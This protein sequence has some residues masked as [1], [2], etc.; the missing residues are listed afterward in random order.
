[1]SKPCSS[2]GKL[3]SLETGEP[4]VESLEIDDGVVT[5]TVHLMKTSACCGDDMKEYT[6]ELEESLMDPLEE[7]IL[8]SHKELTQM[9]EAMDYD[10]FSV[11]EGSC[12]VTE[13]GGSRYAKSYTGVELQITVKCEQDDCDWEFAYTLFGSV[14]NGSFEEV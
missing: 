8:E 5:A 2:C 12:E 6:Y 10:V 9:G 14:P 7:H 4:E 11:E 3:A 13:Q 1:M